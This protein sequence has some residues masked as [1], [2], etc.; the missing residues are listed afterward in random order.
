MSPLTVYARVVV[1]M[2][3]GPSLALT[4]LSPALLSEKAGLDRRALFLQ[5]QATSYLVASPP[6]CLT[7]KMSGVDLAFWQVCAA[8]GQ[9]S[10]RSSDGE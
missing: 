3:L 10:L 4:A 7:Y 8:L 5:I 2:V 9:L 1:V 6:F